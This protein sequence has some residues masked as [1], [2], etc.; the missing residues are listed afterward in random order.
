MISAP[1][2]NH[3]LKDPVPDDVIIHPYHRIVIIEGLYVFLAIEPWKK[4]SLMLDE[5]CLI[6]VDAQDARERLIARHVVSGVAKDISE[7][8]WRAEENDIP[9]L[10]IP[11]FFNF[12]LTTLID[13]RFLLANSLEPTWVVQS[14]DDPYL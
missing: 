8:N 7:A 5:R 9:S 10:L 13:G 12:K 2:F 11:L 4:A 1:S 3:A 6:E 14:S